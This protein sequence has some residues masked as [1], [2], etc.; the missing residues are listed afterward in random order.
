V[1]LN[2]MRNKKSMKLDVT[3]PKDDDMD[4]GSS[5]RE[6]MPMEP[7]AP[8][9]PAAAPAPPAPPAPGAPTKT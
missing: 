2:I 5:W 3:I 9:V 7:P 1:T 6:F 8:P 4:F